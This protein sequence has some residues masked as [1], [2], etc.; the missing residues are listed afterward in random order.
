MNLPKIFPEATPRALRVTAYAFLALFEL[1]GF[2]FSLRALT[3]ST[4]DFVKSVLAFLLFGLL[5]LAAIGYFW[6]FL[7]KIARGN[8]FQKI[9]QYYCERGY[10][11]EM[12]EALRSI[13][14]APT[15]RDKVLMAY[16]LVR[17]EDYTAAERQIADINQPS[18]LQR[19]FAMLTTARLR[20]CMMTGKIEK[21]DRI[22]QDTKQKI[23]G[24]FDLQP[25]L[26]G[27]YKPYFD[28]AYDYF[29][30]AAAYERL[31]GH[32]EQEAAY[33]KKAVFQASNRSASE[34][35]CYTQLLELN[36]LYA[37]GKTE[38][39]HT[40]EQQLYVL[41]DSF[42]P[43]MTQPQK[44]EFRRAIEQSRIFSAHSA[45]AQ[46]AMLTERNLPPQ[47]ASNDALLQFGTPM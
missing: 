40:L 20:L 24:A 46:Q 16:L 33:R 31:Y 1:V 18:L 39:A 11:S 26:L 29:M 12:P 15:K 34:M 23:L 43:P 41:P 5:G 44:D 36:S 47:E 22:Y 2:A 21:F 3:I 27:E 37:A 17:A 10:C 4:S 13:M 32:M 38:E 42:S 6:Q 7:T 28:D 14:P 35:E 30:L 45:M 25:E 9:E 19:E 8:T